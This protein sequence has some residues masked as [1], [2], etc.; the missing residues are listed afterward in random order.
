M[1]EAELRDLIAG[2]ETLHVEFKSDSPSQ[3]SGLSDVD[4]QEAVV[5][6]ANAEGGLLVLGVEDDGTITGLHPS[7]QGRPANGLSGFLRNVLHGASRP[8]IR[9]EIVNTHNGPVAVIHVGQA[10]ALVSTSQGRILK[11][12][13]GAWGDPE[14]AIIYPHEIPALLAVRRQYD[15]TQQPV[16]DLGFEALSLAELDRIRGFVRRQPQADKTL[17]ELDNLA[18]ADA[19]SL[20]YRE[21]Q[22]IYP[23][24]AGLLVAGNITAIRAYIPGHEVGFQQ[25]TADQDVTAND[26]YREPLLRIWEL[27]ENFF[28]NR[29]PQK[30]LRLGLERIAVPQ[31][32]ERAVREAFANALVH[33]D[34]TLL[35]AVY[36]QFKGDKLTISSPG[37]FMDGI[38]VQNLLYVQPNPRN[39]LLAD[40]FKRLGLVERT[41]RGVPRIFGDVLSSGRP[42]PHYQTDGGSVSV[43]IPGG[44]ADVRFVE[45]VIRAQNEHQTMDWRH[46]M[47]MHHLSKARELSA[48]EAAPL[49]NVEEVQTRNIL[50]ELLDWGLVERRRS[51]RNATYHLSGAVYQELNQLD[52]YE[53]R[54]QAETDA[55]E[56][57]VINR[58]R[59]RGRVTRREVIQ[60]NRMEKGKAEYLLQR[61]RNEQKIVLVGRGQAAHYVLPETNSG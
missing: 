5:C 16:R 39:P 33:R 57:W 30:E 36:F 25:L 34:Y 27:Y 50:E 20:V 46:L 4:L 10:S 3:K 54:K 8:E 37:A 13:F 49:A 31:Y 15:H 17:L 44:E 53:R 14:C 11:R 2:G 56:Q 47:V 59:E 24:V 12:R 40:I 55:D 7:H 48:Q 1:T 42:A 19:L 9:A 29:N 58:I 26:F 21:G 18:L 28:L 41:G 22:K 38:T 35:N 61:L 45:M 6:L 23:T 60:D 51:G 52:E 32:P 43:A